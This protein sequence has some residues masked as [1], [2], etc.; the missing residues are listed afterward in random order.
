M[1]PYVR[2][3]DVK[4]KDRVIEIPTESASFYIP[5]DLY[6]LIQSETYGYRYLALYL[7]KNLFKLRKDSI[8]R[9]F[10]DEILRNS[11]SLESIVTDSMN[12]LEIPEE[13][14]G[15]L[16]VEEGTSISI[17]KMPDSFEIWK[18]EELEKWADELPKVGKVTKKAA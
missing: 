13:Y 8:V 9:I 1:Y 18:T 14:L 7:R 3:I 4:L 17:F 5:S 6:V 11:I 15:Y 10:A 2:R 12:L 16:G